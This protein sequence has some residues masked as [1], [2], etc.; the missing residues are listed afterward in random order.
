MLT[1]LRVVTS[2]ISSPVSIDLARRHIRSWQS[3]DDDLLEMYVETATSQAESYLNRTLLTTTYDWTWTDTY[4]PMAD[5]VLAVPLVMVP[6][7]IAFN[8]VSSWNRNVE[9]PRGPVQ[10]VSSIKFG[11]WGEDDAD[12]VDFT[13]D[14]VSDPPR[15][16]LNTRLG[17]NSDYMTVRYLAG[18]G[19]T[20]DDVPVPI[21]HAILLLTAQLYECR[22][23]QEMS[24]PDAFYRLL[25]QFRLPSFPV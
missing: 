3:Q 21:R 19:D 24:F 5:P 1:R 6:Y 15:I 20:S 18:Y 14:L 22:G 2:P 10:S 17:G 9:L 11:T 7:P 4:P 13:S 23:D 25:D 12:F 16:R 8:S